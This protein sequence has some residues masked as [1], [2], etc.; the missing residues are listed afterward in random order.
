[1]V[2]YAVGEGENGGT[3]VAVPR[4]FPTD[5]F[6]KREATLVNLIW[7]IVFLVIFFSLQYCYSRPLDLSSEGRIVRS[8]DPVAARQLIAEHGG[9]NNF[10][11]LDIRTREEHRQGAIPGSRLLDFYDPGFVAAVEALPREKCYLLYCA[12]G[13]RSRSALRLFGELG[14]REVYEYSGGFSRYLRDGK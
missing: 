1:M 7:I 3:Q 13:N 5:N 2:A 8:L 12:S 14:F 6:D 10:V 9:D 4:F 11:L